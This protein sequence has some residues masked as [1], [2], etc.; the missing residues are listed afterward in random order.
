MQIDFN[1]FVQDKHVYF[2]A[3]TCSLGQLDEKKSY[4]NL[5]GLKF[6]TKWLQGK[7]FFFYANLLVVCIH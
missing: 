7:I 2:K 3:N 1:F 5:K 6:L 4:Q